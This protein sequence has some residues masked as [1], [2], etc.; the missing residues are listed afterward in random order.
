MPD[1]IGLEFDAPPVIQLRMARKPRELPADMGLLI[2]GKPG[3]GSVAQLV[4][5]SS[6]ALS[7]LRV[8]WEDELGVV[9]P[10]DASDAAHVD[11]ICGLTLTGAASA[12]EVVVQRAGP[13][14]DASWNWTPGRVWLGAAGALTQIAPAA[15]FDLVV[16][17]AVSATRLYLDFQE[18]IELE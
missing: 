13:V 2:A 3:V 15:G 5:E 11:L 7:A 6:T 10:L 4:R 12:A 8:V 9:R 14:D 18:H 16:G 17:Y 1:A